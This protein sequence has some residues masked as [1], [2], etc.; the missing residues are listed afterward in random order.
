M[1]A[2]V[3]SPATDG[4]SNHVALAV[5]AS[6]SAVSSDLTAPVVEGEPEPLDSNGRGRHLGDL[7]RVLLASVVIA[8]TA[9]VASTHNV[10][11]LEEDVFRLINRLPDLLRIPLD[12]V[13][14]SG[15]LAAVP[16]V[17]I[18]ALVFRNVRLSRDVAIAGASAWVL[19]KVLKSVVGRQRPFAAL[20]AV[21]RHGTDTGLGYPSGHAAV[22]AAIATA[23]AP[24][25][26]RQ[27][28]RAIWTAAVLVGIARIYVGAHLPLDVIG[29]WALGVLVGSAVH[30][31]FGAP[32]GVLQ[33][34]ACVSRSNRS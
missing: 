1:I 9:A 6:R 23:A 8:V 24:Y 29:G 17:A 34:T 31:A 10:S 11:R 15:A 19:A 14:Q 33:P 28:R 32:N 20:D 4:T 12:Y 22:A 18:G 27:L 7:V 25:L 5:D 21:F 3:N 16:V 26:N 30:L 2:I 13:M